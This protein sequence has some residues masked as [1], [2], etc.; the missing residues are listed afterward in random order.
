MLETQGLGIEDAGGCVPEGHAD[1]PGLLLWHV[2]PVIEDDIQDAL[3]DIVSELYSGTYVP[4]AVM[5][6]NDSIF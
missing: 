1:L 5:E 6:L 3:L 2:A 4:R